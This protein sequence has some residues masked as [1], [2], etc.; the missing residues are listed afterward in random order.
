[1]NAD[2][3]MTFSLSNKFFR[4]ILLA[5]ILIIGIALS[6]LVSALSYYADEK[7]IWREFNEEVEN[8]YSAL[9]RE[10]DINLDALKSV[11]ALYF[12]S[13]NIER[14]EFRNFTGYIL[15]QY[16]DIQALEWIPRVPDSRREKYE[17]SAR[18]EGFADFQF[19]ERIA[20]GK[21]KRADKRKEYFPVYF[22][23]P[24][25]GNEIALGFDL[26]SNPKRWEALEVARKTGEIVATAKITLVQEAESQFGFIIFAPVYM[27]GALLN[28]D[29][30]RWDNLKGFCAAVFRISSSVKESMSYLAPAGI[31]FSIYDTSAPGKEQLLYSHTSRARKT[32]ISNKEPETSLRITKTLDVGGRKWMLIYSAAPEFLA[33]KGNWYS[34]G[35]LLAGLAITGLITGFLFTSARHLGNAEDTAKDLSDANADLSNEIIEHKM[36]RDELSDRTRQATLGA[37]IGTILVQ[38]RDLR[39]LLQSCA[40][41]IVNNL[42]AAFARIW[43]LNERDNVLELQA[44]AGM[45]TH[46]DGPH[47]RV[48]V[49]KFKI[50]LI[51]QEKKPHLTNNVMGDPRISDPQWARREGMVAFAGHPLIVA[52]KLIGVMALFS[53][54]P[55]KEPTL[56]VLASIADEIALGIKRKQAEETNKRN[57][58]IQNILNSL[59]K[60]SLEE[61]PLRELLAK[62][63]D[64]ILSVS[65]LPLVPKGGIFVVEDKPD[66]LI[67]IANRGFSLPIQEICAKVPFGGCLCGLSAASKQIQFADCMDERHKNHYD[68]IIDH[69]HYNVPI[70]SMGKVLGVL[71]VYLQEGHKQEISE[72][73]FLQAVVNTLAGIIERKQLENALQKFNEEL[74]KK[75]KERTAELEKANTELNKLFNAIEQSEESIVITDVNGAIEYVNPAFTRK[76]GYSKKEAIEQNPR[77]LQSGLTPIEIYDELWRTIL[78]GVPWK[79]TLINKKKSGEIYYE[80]AT[81]APVFDEHGKIK[82]FVA[83]KTDVTDRIMAEEELK[84]KNTELELAKEIAESANRAKSDFLANMSHELRTP[85]NSIIGFSDILED[86]MAGPMADNQKELLNDISTSGKH[87]LSLINDILDL[88]KVEAGTMELELNE[89]NLEEMIDGSLVMFKEKA[90]KHNIKIAAEVEAGIGNIVAD[91]RKIKRVLFNLLS[92][93]FKFT[94][95]GGSVSVQARRVSNVGAIRRVAHEEGRGS[96]SPLQEQN[97]IEISVT[98]TGIGISPEDQKKLFQPFQ[99]MDSALSRKYSG[100]GLGLNLC[101]QFIELLGGRIWVES[102]VDK[103]SRFVFVVPINRP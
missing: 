8:R 47:G 26:A 33:A 58:Q 67:L 15:K 30:A 54:A 49:G 65:F 61:Y 77:I 78:S 56:M 24:D 19:T 31:D 38:D 16:E 52:D 85:L 14:S 18:R 5:V 87:L 84:R 23:E 74:M 99:Q 93:A 11:Q 10:I 36:A 59:L 2:K 21:M 46:I 25:K 95:N 64:I 7:L 63:L 103:G 55:L 45:Y 81:I 27:R 48:P 91:K 80:D 44:S 51:A 53:K 83:A 98:D 50:G 71:V 39:S 9:K 13:E 86:G 70:L 22:I 69:G 29:Q 72:L 75:V 28:S 96:A 97:F 66:V 41:A 68:G 1:M 60:V 90:M 94:S 35:F 43:A 73:E 32:L 102:E 3:S 79:G 57:L 20:P 88:S 12:S 17:S 82:H 100:T 37:N 6:I 89:F 92:N 34:W 62:A 101:K 4:T 76:T 40:E 42:D